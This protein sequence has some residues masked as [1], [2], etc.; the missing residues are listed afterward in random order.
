MKFHIRDGDSD[1]P[2]TG[3]V[4]ISNIYTQDAYAASWVLAD[5]MRT[6]MPRACG[7]L[8]HGTGVSGSR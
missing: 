5:Q 3:R 2:A 6:A 1:T 8:G 4:V 7:V